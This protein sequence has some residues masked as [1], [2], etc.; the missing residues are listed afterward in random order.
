M[1][2][3]QFRRHEEILALKVDEGGIWSEDRSFRCR[4]CKSPAKVNP[5]TERV[6][7]CS[8]CQITSL[9]IHDQSDKFEPVFQ[10]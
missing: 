1:P 4:K 6:L 8:H 9:D 3:S 2:T 10:N 5:F 7:G